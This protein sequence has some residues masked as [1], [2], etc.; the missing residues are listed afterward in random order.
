MDGV[1]VAFGSR[2]MTAEAPRHRAKDGNKR[3]ALVLVQMIE[4]YAAIFAWLL[5][6]FGPSSDTLEA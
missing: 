3:R 6:S 2:G 4:F 5:C 1:N